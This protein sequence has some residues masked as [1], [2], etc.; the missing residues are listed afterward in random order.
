MFLSQ[1]LNVPRQLRLF[2]LIR[3]CVTLSMMYYLP[4]KLLLQ[5][6]YYLLNVYLFFFLAGLQ[7][8]VLLVQDNDSPSIHTNLAA[9]LTFSDL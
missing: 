8:V 7:P 5:S 4:V 6:S 1:L 9:W 2:I 3:T